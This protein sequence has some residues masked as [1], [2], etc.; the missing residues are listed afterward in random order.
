MERER[1]RKRERERGREGKIERERGRQNERE[2]ERN[3]RISMLH[4]IKICK[5]AER[6]CWQ[7]KVRSGLFQKLI[8]SLFL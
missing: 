2:R 1:E 4:S 6:Y 7:S 8:Q 3:L 5:W